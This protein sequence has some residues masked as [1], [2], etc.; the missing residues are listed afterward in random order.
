MLVHLLVP[1]EV[2]TIL[3]LQTVFFEVAD[4]LNQR[5]I[6]VKTKHPDQG[7][8]LCP[9]DLLLGRVTSTAPSGFIEQVVNL[10]ARGQFVPRIVTSFWQK[11]MQDVF[12]I[13][14]VRSKW[15][16]SKRNLQINDLV[17]VKDS[18]F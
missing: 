15:H 12:H 8:Y 17:L 10:S 6:G 4:L 2:L 3:E 1:P 16:T 9:N 18:K 5:P 13:M 11:W 7:T 14:I